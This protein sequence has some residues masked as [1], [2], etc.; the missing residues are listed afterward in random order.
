VK[1]IVCTESG[2]RR[3]VGIA[4]RLWKEWVVTRSFGARVS[5]GLTL[6]GQ[7]LP[8]GGIL[9]ELSHEVGRRGSLRGKFT[10][11]KNRGRRNLRLGLLLGTVLF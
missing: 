8:M 1:R 6:E 3:L 11:T 4:A 2:A 7:G 5:A 10:E 9:E